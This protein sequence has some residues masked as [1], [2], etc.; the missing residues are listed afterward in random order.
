MQILRHENGKNVEIPN[1]LASPKVTT[2]KLTEFVKKSETFRRL[3]WINEV[4]D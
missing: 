1:T 3:E 2:E 4:R